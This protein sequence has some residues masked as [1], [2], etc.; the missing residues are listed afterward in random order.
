MFESLPSEI[1]CQILAE[2]DY[3]VTH[4]LDKIRRIDEDLY[5][6]FSSEQCLSYFREITCYKHPDMIRLFPRLTMLCE[7][8][9]PIDKIHPTSRSS[10]RLIRSRS[11]SLFDELSRYSIFPNLEHLSIVVNCLDIH[12]GDNLV[13]DN[14]TLLE[15]M[16]IDYPVDLDQRFGHLIELSRLLILDKLTI[17]VSSISDNLLD[18]ISRIS[19]LSLLRIYISGCARRSYIIP[20]LVNLESLVIQFDEN[21]SHGNHRLYVENGHKLSNLEITGIILGSELFNLDELYIGRS[22]QF[23]ILEYCP[24]ISKLRLYGLNSVTVS[25]SSRICHI[26]LFNCSDMK[27]NF[28]HNPEVKILMCERILYPGCD[29]LSS[30]IDSVSSDI[31][32]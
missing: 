28:D 13:L 3:D 25:I 12:S 14:L 17:L 5:S 11:S 16:F 32:Y 29:N 9:S 8:S 19:N 1:L 7:S 10:L 26:S 4:S 27:L 2:I 22:H 6:L 15:I 20:R 18:D 24:N 23:N 30:E 21:V 31:E